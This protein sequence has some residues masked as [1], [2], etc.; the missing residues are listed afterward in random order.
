LICLLFAACRDRNVI[1]L[2][3]PRFGP[4]SLICGICISSI[5]TAPAAKGKKTGG[6]FP[7][8]IVITFAADSMEIIGVKAA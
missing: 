2:V 1:P 3:S 4:A 8:G 6:E 7:A 5:L